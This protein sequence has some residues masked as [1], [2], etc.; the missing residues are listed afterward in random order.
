MATARGANTRLLAKEELAYG[1]NPGGADWRQFPFIPPLDL[2]GAQQ[3]LESPVIGISAGRDPADPF[4]DAVTVDGRLIVPLD[5]SDIGFWLDKLFGD[6]ATTGTTHYTH[7]FKSGSATA[8]PSFSAEVGYPDVPS[9]VLMT[10][11]KAGSLEV[12]A[13]PTGRPQATIGIIAQDAARSTAS[14]DS[15]P[16]LA[17][18][19]EQFNN[20]QATVKRAGTAI[21]YVTA[22]SVSFTNN[23]EA[24][25]DI[26]S[27]TTIKEA[28]EQDAQLSGSMTL[29][30]SDDTLLDDSEGTAPIALSLGWEIGATKSILFEMPRIFL[31]RRKAVAQGR[32]GVDVTFD[33]R[34][35]YDQ[36]EACALKVTL[37]NQTVSY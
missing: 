36:T 25:R 5:L 8:L 33:W 23:L 7:I 15:S 22:M 19:Y 1:A 4:H 32:A 11:A 10:G 30:L 29:R 20:F 18:T 21:G 13:A 9:Y 26:G 16:T 2:G 14:V 34:G 6:P 12:A 28:I 37:K 31:P 27:G 17:A 35:A 3:L 24:V